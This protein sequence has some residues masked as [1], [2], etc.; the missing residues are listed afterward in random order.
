[1]NNKIA[2]I[3]VDYIKELDWIDKIAGLTQIARVTQGGV[4]KR[5]PI[6]CDMTFDDA[7]VKGCYDDLMPNSQYASVVFFEDGSFTFSRA[8]GNKLYYESRLRMVVW[9]NYKKL[10]GGC[11]STSEY[12]ISIIKALP[13]FA[14]NVG[15]MLRLSVTV[16]SQM[17]RTSGVFDKY[18]FDEKRSQYL[19]LPYDFFA[20]DIKTT[21]FII[22]ECVEPDPG[23]CNEC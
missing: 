23:G 19:M 16:T 14:Q 13:A 17:P 15:D 10:T 12:I 1:M 2:N 11:G 6:S 21:F 8:E 4:E 18:T 9:L 20:L 5:F 3:I 22:S 7:C